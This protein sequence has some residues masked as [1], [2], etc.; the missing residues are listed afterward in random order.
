MDLGPRI[1]SPMSPEAWSEVRGLSQRLADTA[2]GRFRLMNET[3]TNQEAMTSLY[4][5]CPEFEAAL[6][7]NLAASLEDKYKPGRYQEMVEEM[8]S[9]GREIVVNN[10][11]NDLESGKNI[12]VNMNHASL[13]RSGIGF[14]LLSRAL[15]DKGVAFDKAIIGGAA[16]LNVEVRLD[17]DEVSQSSSEPENEEGFMPAYDAIGLVSNHFFV[18]VPNTKRA[19]NLREDYGEEVKQHNEQMKQTLAKLLESDE[20]VLL[21]MLGSGTH[22]R[23]RE[24]DP[25]TIEMSA[26]SDG[27]IEMII[28]NKLGTVQAALL[29]LPGKPMEFYLLSGPGSLSS[30]DQMHSEM[31]RTARFLSQHAPGAF[32][33]YQKP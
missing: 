17:D 2:G 25:T 4:V 21:M 6:V 16:L 5:P 10:I 26:I 19:E 28:E 24:G 15:E 32:Y 27:T 13:V 14:R 7:D 1:N 18:S 23:P 3:A 20:G 9:G 30:K 33:I 11:A 22:D 12:A 31:G 8:H 29:D